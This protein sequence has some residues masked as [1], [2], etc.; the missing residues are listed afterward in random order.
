MLTTHLLAALLGASDCFPPV[1]EVL[2]ARFLR[3]DT[4][5][6]GSCARYRWEFD[7]SGSLRLTAVEARGRIAAS[8][9]VPG[10]GRW[11]A[12]AVVGQPWEWRPAAPD[13]GCGL[14]SLGGPDGPSSDAQVSDGALAGGCQDGS[15]IDVMILT[16]PAAQEEAGGE[17]ELVVRCNLGIELANT[18][19]INSKVPAR[20]RLVFL[21]PVQYIESTF[22]ADINALESKDDGILDSIHAMRDAIGADLVA[23][24]RSEGEFCGVANIMPS[25]TGSADRGF[26]VTAQGCLANQTFAHE[27][28]HNL[29]CCHATGDGGGGGCETGGLFPYSLGW[30]FDGT[31]GN[32]YRT[33]MAYSPGESIDHFSSPEISFEGVPTGVAAA[34]GGGAGADNARTIRETAPVA[35]G[36]RCSISETK[37]GDCDENGTVDAIDLLEGTGSDCNGN[38]VLDFCDLQDP[39]SDT[40]AD[41]QL[42]FCEA[43]YGDLNLDGVI[44]G[45]DLGILLV[46]WGGVGPLGDLDN[47]S[48]IDGG[49]LGIMLVRW[50]GV[51]LPK[52]VVSK[53]TPNFGGEEGGTLITIRGTGFFGT[54][55][56]DVGGDGATNVEIVDA[57]TLVARTPPGEL[58]PVAVSVTTS[59]GTG[60]RKRAFFYVDV[61][62]PEWAELIEPVP[63]PAVI[64][65]PVMRDEILATGLAWRVR[66]AATQIEMLVVPPGRFDMGCSP[67]LAF[68]CDGDESPVHEV[69]LTKS[70]YLARYETTQQQWQGVMGSNPSAFQGSAY[71]NAPIRPVEKARYSQILEFMT[72]TGMRLPTEAE[73]EWSYRAGTVTAFHGSPFVP[74]GTDIDANLQ[75]LAWFNL[76]SQSQPQPVGGKSGNGLG[77]HD[78]AGNIW[79]CV[80]DRY[81][82]NYGSAQPVFDPTGPTSG[83]LRVL[84]GGAWILTGSDCR[85]SARHK[86]DPSSS[87]NFVGFRAAKWP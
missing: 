77:L 39:A 82:S 67:S 49:D 38:D 74:Q 9:I 48:S 79:E 26:S 15:L 60:T 61:V 53:V 18:A 40:D 6:A 68:P 84:R 13:R 51:P 85:S 32:Q 50:G 11:E 87:L 16:T 1:V 22:Q 41:G 27:I 70:F 35:A 63:D 72:A 65:D 37:L 30:R 47:N 56:V 12:S 81:A 36:Y 24:I 75:P 76:N 57:T 31:S 73:W 25:S 71:P 14:D 54:P 43:A 4:D 34:G 21:T 33:V 83:V 86:I 8:V 66:H 46:N 28:G 80:A 42:D 10:W 52:P 59:G 5:S 55:A 23:L 62:V 69:T 19:Y 3:S 7:R 20:L 2:G 29:G 45:A 44:D 58:G 17:P 78:M 64:T